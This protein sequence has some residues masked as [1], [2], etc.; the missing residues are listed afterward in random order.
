[1]YIDA[2][3]EYIHFTGYLKDPGKRVK[4]F[5]DDHVVMFDSIDDAETRIPTLK[6]MMGVWGL[7]VNDRKSGI[8]IDPKYM[9]AKGLVMPQTVAGVPVVRDYKYLGTPISYDW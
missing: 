9:A 5:M 6:N 1:M 7:K 2:M 4:I 3:W 8:M